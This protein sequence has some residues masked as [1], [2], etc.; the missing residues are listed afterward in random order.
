MP[1]RT[2]WFA[3]SRFT[4]TARFKNAPGR[5][6]DRYPAELVPE[7]GFRSSMRS[8]GK[9][10]GIFR[11]WWF[12]SGSGGRY[13]T[14]RDLPVPLRLP[15]AGRGANSG[16]RSRVE[17]GVR[18]KRLGRSPAAAAPVIREGCWD[19]SQHEEVSNSFNFKIVRFRCWDISHLWFSRPCWDLT[20]RSVL[21]FAMRHG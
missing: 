15:V 8:E 19:K 5:S 21:E 12:C 6:L 3:T 1:V 7:K 16:R 10:P 4:R 2:T 11:F 20:D 18:R 13:D 14:V 17:I 9:A